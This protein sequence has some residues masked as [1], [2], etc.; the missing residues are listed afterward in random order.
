[1]SQPLRTSLMRP[2]EHAAGEDIAGRFVI[3]D[4]ALVIDRILQ[5]R[6]ALGMNVFGLRMHWVGMPHAMM[7]ASLEKFCDQVLRAI[8]RTS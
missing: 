2:V 4:P 1:M 5:Y 7:M 3:G 8:T 6:E